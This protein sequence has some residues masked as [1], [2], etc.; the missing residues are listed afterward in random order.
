[1]RKG[2]FQHPPS[3]WP[4]ISIDT[5]RE[6]QRR[7]QPF[8]HRTPVFRSRT[9]DRLASRDGV[10]RML[11]FK[12]ENF[13]KCGAFKARGAV[14]A[15]LSLAEEEARRG[16]LTHSSGNHAQALA[17]AARL[18]GIQAYVVMPRDAAPT[19]RRAVA[20]LGAQVIDCEP[21]QE[22]REATAFALA[23]KTGALMIH[24][25]DQPAVIAGQGTVALELIEE[26]PDLD[27]VIL[28]IGG[29][30]LAGGV[31]LACHGL[32]A[33]LR[34]IAAEPELACDAFE[35][36]QL[37]RPVPQKA[38]R[39]IADGLRAP[40]GQWTFPL[41]RDLID[42]IILISEEAILNATRL[43]IE[44][45]KL[46]IEPSAGVAVAAAL[47]WGHKALD[48]SLRRIAVVLSGGNA[49]LPALFGNQV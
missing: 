15:V 18:R 41:V 49:E 39:S 16:V 47:G 23:Q 13:Q 30:G 21:T 43:V 2:F 11:F 29:G 33:G 25:Y 40:L 26:V 34:I 10:E 8:T 14:N 17:Y 24:P 4:P 7:I 38:P 31:A 28:P 42:E 36:K 22:S 37:G 27:A 46:V 48:P 6:A 12:G 35:A 45:M 5:I 20:E 1:M 44:R 3:D 32:G 19:K 9:L